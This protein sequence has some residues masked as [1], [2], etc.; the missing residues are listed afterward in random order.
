[1]G[2]ESYHAYAGSLVFS[3]RLIMILDSSRTRFAPS[4]R[5]GDPPPD[6]LIYISGHARW[7]I[8]THSHHTFAADTVTEIHTSFSFHPSTHPSTGKGCW[9]RWV[10][11]ISMRRP[12]CSGVCDR[13]L[14]GA[15]RNRGCLGWPLPWLYQRYAH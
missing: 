6:H 5:F 4:P 2:E 1:M 9:Y 15:W 10:G 13:R 11:Q 12:L 3:L 7:K 14:E 8:D